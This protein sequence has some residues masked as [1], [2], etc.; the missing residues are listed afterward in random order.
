MLGTVKKVMLGR[1][2]GFIRPDADTGEDVFFHVDAWKGSSDPQQ[3]DRV[4]YELGADRQ[5]RSK[6]I[7]VRL[8]DDAQE[9]A[10]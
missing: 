7:L 5:G 3:G 1:G 9:A 4:E 10:A 2:F 6:A 8:R